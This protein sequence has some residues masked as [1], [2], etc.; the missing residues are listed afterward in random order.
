MHLAAFWKALCEDLNK[1]RKFFIVA[2]AAA[3]R[4]SGKPG[5]SLG[6]VRLKTHALLLAI[7][8]NV[9][10]GRRLF[11]DDVPNASIHGLGELIF[12]DGPSF[13]PADQQVGKFIA[14]GKA[15]DMS[16]EYSI[17]A[18]VHGVVCSRQMPRA[19]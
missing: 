18:E 1:L 17:A 10:S 15:A 4:F 7:V 6:N 13:F 3:F 2:A 9:Y 16:N 5:H 8:A 11:F 14:A 19:F 12:V